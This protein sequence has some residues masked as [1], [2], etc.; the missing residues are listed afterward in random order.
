[1][2]SAAHRRNMQRII[3]LFLAI[4]AMVAVIVFATY[5][6][7]P[8]K[9]SSTQWLSSDNHLQ[10]FYKNSDSREWEL[11]DLTN[12]STSYSSFISA[13]L[14]DVTADLATHRGISQDEAADLLQNENYRIYTTLDPEL[15]TVIEEIYIDFDDSTISAT[16]QQHIQSGITMLDP[17]TGHILAMVGSLGKN[18][19]STIN[20]ARELR[21][22]GT[23]ITPLTSYAPAIEFGE[24]NPATIIDEY[25]IADTLSTPRT[26]NDGIRNSIQS[27][28][29]HILRS[30]GLKES[31]DF[32]T[33]NLGLPLDPADQNITALGN[34]KLYSGVSTE[35]MAAAYAVF[36]NHGVYNNPKTY[37]WV[38]DSAGEI[39][40]E[41]PVSSYVAMKEST[42]YLMTK[43][44]Q[45]VVYNGTG[46]TAQFEGM[47][48]AGKTGTTEDNFDRYFVG[49]SP[50]YVAAVW[51]GYPQNEYIDYS[52]N[53][54]SILWKQVMQA[55]HSDLPY[56]EFMYSRD[57]IITIEI[58][59]DS[60][61]LCSQQCHEDPRGDRKMLVE[62]TEGTEPTTICNFHSSAL[63]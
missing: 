13:V 2:A 21:Q 25:S 49:F 20:Y 48:I 50:Y 18:N 16:D 12:N 15:Q 46:G 61:M 40:L 39:L 7:G 42:A 63:N 24:I 1:M 62:V 38:E 10:F 4:L 6:S 22:P 19:N 60:G 5:S 45:D 51:V 17:K 53:P 9:G 55:V 30:V 58:C 27:I 34:G 54:A 14:S 26:V 41:K 11:L 59:R 23:A 47:S 31:F 44:L 32:A 35:D 36:A 43:M 37:L 56:T 3:F 57:G 8:S 29:I 28:D 33:N 52:F